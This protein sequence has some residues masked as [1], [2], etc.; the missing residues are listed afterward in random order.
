MNKKH[1]YTLRLFLLVHQQ[2]YE[3]VLKFFGRTVTGDIKEME[4]ET[5]V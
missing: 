3:D 5:K 2:K 4:F 1:E